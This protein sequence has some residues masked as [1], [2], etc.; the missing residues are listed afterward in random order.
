MGGRGSN[1]MSRVGGRSIQRGRPNDATEWY[2][3]GDGM[4]INQYL[5]GRV[6]REEFGELSQEEKQ[7]LRDLD[8]ATDGKVKQDVLYRSV[9]ASAIFSGGD[10]DNLRQ[11]LQY[12]PDS[13]GKGA[14]AQSISDDVRN[15]IDRA[16][17][18]TVTEK[19]F[20][21]TTKDFNI[22]RD[23]GGF[24]GS[25]HPIVLEIK[26]TPTTK[27]VDVSV[28]DRSVDPSQAQKEV[29][30]ARN[31]SFKIEDVVYQD[32]TVLVKVKMV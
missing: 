9:D 12:G 3:S 26:T 20:V 29:L 24:T 4:W 1:S 32:G 21:S 27:G 6:N 13:W 15:M 25:E 11:Y 23:F 14:Y 16:V 30:L 19:G 10:L 28:Y 18:S 2:V 8:I 17:G 31:Q 7:F 22:A 5:R